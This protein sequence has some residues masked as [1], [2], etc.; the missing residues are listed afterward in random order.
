[1]KLKKIIK[2]HSLG[3]LPSSKLMKMKWNPVTDP[4]PVNESKFAGWIAGYN[5]K[6]N[7]I[8]KSEANSLYAAKQ[9]A[10]K[11]LNVPKSKV[12]LMFIK[13]AVDESINERLSRQALDRLEGLHNLRTMKTF[14][15]AGKD[16]AK[17]LYDEGFENDEIL[18]F[19]YYKL[20]RAGIR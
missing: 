11:K 9:L 7:E 6:R 3:E 10:I 20:Q 13:P 19:F 12:G 18:D 14:L 2:E 1:M 15:A 5:N 4:E 17:E 8:K 16:L